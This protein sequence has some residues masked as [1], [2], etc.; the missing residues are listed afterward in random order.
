MTRAAGLAP[1]KEPKRLLPDNPE[2]RPGDLFFPGWNAPGREETRIAVD[3]TCPLADSSWSTLT[4]AQKTARAN[5]VGTAGKAA[6]DRKAGNIGTEEEQQARGNSLTMRER[7][8]LQNIHFWPIALEGDGVPSESFMSF[9]NHVCD[10]AHKL[11]GVNRSTFKSYF[12]SRL[13]NTLHQLS[14]KLSL[15]QIAG[16]RVTLVGLE[17]AVSGL[18]A[19]VDFNQESQTILPAYASQRR[20]WRNRNS[21]LGVR[22]HNI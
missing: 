1:A 19:S 6:E 2:E 3:F 13:A 5:V 14:A 16:A 17:N 20:E 21:N 4:E 11:K 7:C 9:F 10:T 15:R 8:E 18:Q 12:A 22:L